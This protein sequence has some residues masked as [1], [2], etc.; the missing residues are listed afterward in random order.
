[1]KLALVG[2]R[3]VGKTS[4]L[5]RLQLYL[6][7]IP[8]HNF[9]CLDQTIEESSEATIPEIFANQGEPKFRE[10]ESGNFKDLDL[11][12]KNEKH[13]VVACGA[14]FAG[15]FPEGWKV[16]WLQRSIDLQKALFLDRP[17]I[18]K[19][20]MEGLGMSPLFFQKRT[21]RYH[22]QADD[23][24]LLEEHMSF[25]V[26]GERAWA[27]HYF[28]VCDHLDIP[29]NFFFTVGPGDSTEALRAFPGIELR[30]DL[31]SPEK[32]KACFAGRSPQI[33]LSFRD[34]HRVESSKRWMSKA[35]KIDWALE[36]GECP[37]P[38]PHILSLHQ[39]KDSFEETVRQFPESSAI[40][41]LAV[42]IETFE[43]LQAG[44][45]WWAKD[46][47]KRLFLPSSSNGRWQW[48]RRWMSAQM[49][50]QFFRLCEGAVNDQ[51]TLLQALEITESEHF[52]AVLGSPVSHSLTPWFHKEFFALQNMPVFAIDLSVEEW[53]CGLPFLNALGL[54]FAAVTSPLKKCAEALVC[55]EMP[56]NTLVFHKGRWL[57]ANT[58]VDGLAPMGE[59]LKD[60]SVAL[61]GGG[62]TLKALKSRVP[63]L[64]AYSSRSGCLRKT[65]ASSFE[66]SSPTSVIWAVGR[67]AFDKEG[68]F[69]PECWNPTTVYDLNYSAD[70]PGR[71]CAKRFDCVYVSGIEM[72]IEQARAQQKFWSPYVGE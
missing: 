60:Q 51:P 65:E 21:Q 31:L 26:D 8:K 36:L 45:H 17:G 50:F 13:A 61:W 62:G 16:L 70:S 22:D 69:P 43:E 59:S 9:F 55:S 4:F 24:L 49:P 12:L 53:N 34:P 72:F 33:L 14:G 71:A 11:S 20:S 54:K 27:R 2:H 68:V 28:G 46:P 19:D 7:E 52:A 18:D 56:I 35:E 10:L 47:K 32:I 6:P 23:V 48:Y 41:K 15:P 3:G 30:D 42:P 66:E 44:H 37:L 29:Q 38:S 25:N 5:Q 58:D 39:R 1:M 67:E 57:G 63:Q 40:L 64:V